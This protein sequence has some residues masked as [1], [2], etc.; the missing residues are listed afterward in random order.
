MWKGLLVDIKQST[1]LRV[2]CL[3]LL[4]V[5]HLSYTTRANKQALIAS[6]AD[7]LLF[8]LSGI[9]YQ[10]VA[11]ILASLIRHGHRAKPLLISLRIA[12][13]PWKCNAKKMF[14]VYCCL[15][16]SLLVSWWMIL[17]VLVAND[18]VDRGDILQWL[19]IAMRFVW[20]FDI[21]AKLCTI[22]ASQ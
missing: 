1:W 15:P 14:L 19:S 17:L 13:K 5:D 10:V 3:N 20:I 4:M 12:L 2:E 6:Q 9:I 22:F 18:F 21:G 11:I 8:D 16:N 7:K